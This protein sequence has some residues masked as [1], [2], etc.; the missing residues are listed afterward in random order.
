MATKNLEFAAQ[1]DAWT[2]KTEKR[3]EAVFK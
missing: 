1:V 3:S 2:R